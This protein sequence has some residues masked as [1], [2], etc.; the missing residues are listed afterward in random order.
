MRA[1]LLYLLLLISW[2]ALGAPAQADEGSIDARKVAVLPLVVEGSIDDDA[3]A[4]LMSGLRDGLERGEFTI[5]PQNEVDVLADSPCDR[6]ACYGKLRSE[7]GVSHLVRATVKIENRDYTM[8]VELIDAENGTVVASSDDRCDICGLEEVGEML[9]SQGALL[10]AKID[11]MGAGPAI[12]VVDSKPS[13]A[14]VMIDGEVVGTTPLERSVIAGEHV[15]RVTA[16]G[17]VAEERE[18]TFVPGV[19]ESISLELSR[20]AGSKKGRL[21]GALSLAGGVVALGGGGALLYLDDQFKCVDPTDVDAEGDC[22][23]YYNYSPGGGVLV[24]AGAALTTLG[25]V[26]LLRHRKPKSKA[27]ASAAIT[28]TGIWLRGRF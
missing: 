4:G 24:A 1:A 3:K 13:G 18:V 11:A 7:L 12:L 28:P 21:F 10:R 15:L 26:L 14:T 25:V 22:R 27:S 9:S 6:Q 17:Y 16:D 23:E 20:A 19:S 5:A 2:I 8:Q